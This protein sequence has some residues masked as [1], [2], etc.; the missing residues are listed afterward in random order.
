MSTRPILVL[1][2]VLLLLALSACGNKGPLVLPD[3]ADAD[4]DAAVYEMPAD[5]EAADDRDGDDDDAVGDDPPGP[6]RD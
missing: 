6:P 2:L 3:R 5:A 4:V 1:P